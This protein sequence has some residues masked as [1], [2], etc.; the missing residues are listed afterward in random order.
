MIPTFLFPLE[1]KLVEPVKYYYEMNGKNIRNKI[2]SIIGISFN[3][4]NEDI[5]NINNLINVL[6]NAS[7]V[8]DDI[9]DNSVVRRNKECAHKIYGIP[10]SLNSAYLTVFKILNEM[11]KDTL[12]SNTLKHKIIENIYL[13]HVGQGMDIYYT[14]TKTIPT[15]DDYYKMIEYKTG[16]LFLSML[17]LFKEKHAINYEMYHSI[18]LK[19]SYFY[20]IR[21]DYINVTDVNY[22]NEK[23]FCQDIDEQK[24]SFLITYA[25]NN[26][27]K[28]YEKI[29]NLLEKKKKRKLVLLFYKNG[30][31]NDVFNILKKLKNEIIE[32]LT[33]ENLTDFIT[34][35][36][37]LQINT[38]NIESFNSFKS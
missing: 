33:K 16:M 22:W 35:F 2:C 26:K 27:L 8:I 13:T 14:K 32:L 25:Y 17:E 6:H 5:E 37:S 11:N 28:N 24:I 31:L 3:I 38:F 4:S 12:Y 36:E 30:L 9:E 20:Q 15:L 10:L 29:L 21:D 19:F 34:I 23:G 7:L 18:L 1:E